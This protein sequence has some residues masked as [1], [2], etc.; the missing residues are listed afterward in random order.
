MAAKIYYEDDVSTETLRGSRIA[1]L[2]YGSQGRA[3]SLNLKDSGHDV[4]VGLR[5]DSS[6]WTKVEA[7]GLHVANVHEAVADA[8]LVA[9]LVPDQH[10]AA[11]FAESIEP[12][13]RPGTTLLFAH[14]FS[15]HFGQIRPPEDNDVVMIAP[16]APG[17]LVRRTFEEG[18]GTP[19]LVA[20]HQDS[21][22]SARDRALAYARGL[23]CT[24]AGVIQTTFAEETETDLFGEQAVLC[25]GTSRLIQAGFETLVE[26]GYQPEIAYFECLHELK[27]IVDLLYE[28]GLGHMRRAISDTAEYGDLTRGRKVVTEETEEAMRVILDDI[29]SGSFAREWVT[30]NRAGTPVLDA[31][32]RR[33]AQHPIEEV[34]TNLRKMMSWIENPT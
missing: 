19:A 2:G 28:G 17:P 3:H 15:I 16:K 13:L 25:G 34:G 8:D 1:V 31:E 12:N 9:V 29:R 11:V 18:K 33:Q 27:L 23:G 6:S 32:R 5:K 20:V 22:G 26:A 24:R 7:D 10:Q 14:G 30:E 4:I 21:S